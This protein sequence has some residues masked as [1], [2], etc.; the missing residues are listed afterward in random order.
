M[1]TQHEITVSNRTLLRIVGIVILTLLAFRFINS[2]IHPLTLIFVAFF[3]ALALNPIV[4]WLT[5]KLRS[6]SRVRATAL[7]YLSVIV[8]LGSFFSLVIPPLISQTR[9][10][11]NDVP[12]IVNDFQTQESGVAG[13]ARRYGLDKQLQQASKDITSRYNNVADTLLTTG[14]RV[15]ATFV[16]IVTVLVLTFMMLVEGPAW[17]ERIWSLVPPKKRGHQKQTAQKMYRAVTAF[18]NGQVLLA[19]IAGFMALIALIIASTL[20]NVSINV[21]ALA[22]IVA[23]FALVPL[24][25]NI[26]STAIVVLICLLSSGN[27]AIIM[28]V[29]F[30]VY[31]QIENATLQPYIQSRANEL[32]PLTVF[33]AALVGIGFGGILGAFVAIPAAGALKILFD[34]HL[35]HRLDEYQKK[36]GAAN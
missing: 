4:S 36:P 20:L 29:Y 5:K 34:D 6:N 12:R 28:L 14:K 31:Q 15:G 30:L 27:L 3:L 32:T 24:I 11:V 7:A 8:I 19:A 1:S 21:V 35:R 18:V 9:D 16:S 17:M 25:G 13:F 10:F 2:I 26:I 23:L 33:I 22:G